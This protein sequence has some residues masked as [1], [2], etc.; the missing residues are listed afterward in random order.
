[1]TLGELMSGEQDS[2]Y[3]Y[4][5]MDAFHGIVESKRLWASDLKAMNDPREVNLGLDFVKDFLGNLGFLPG[6][7]EN[8]FCLKVKE[9]FSEVSEEFVFFFY[10][11]ISRKR[12]LISVARICRSRPRCYDGI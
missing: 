4:C 6:T 1:M 5:S 2:L 12:Q 9:N 8:D 11:L 7:P 3:Y 10:L